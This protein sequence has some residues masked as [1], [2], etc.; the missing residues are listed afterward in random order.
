[1]SQPQNLVF[2][3]PRNI[4]AFNIHQKYFLM[5]TLLNV[6]IK[7]YIIPHNFKIVKPFPSPI[8]SQKPVAITKLVGGV[9]GILL[10]LIEDCTGLDQHFLYFTN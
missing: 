9:P 10:K 2:D 6:F 5:H 7:R 3:G 1:M 4:Y 8:W